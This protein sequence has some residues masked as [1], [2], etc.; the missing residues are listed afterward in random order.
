MKIDAYDTDTGLTCERCA[1]RPAGQWH[2][3]AISSRGDRWEYL[4][5]TCHVEDHRGAM[6]RSACNARS[7]RSLREMLADVAVYVGLGL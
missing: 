3:S 1:E 6:G 7:R 4:C 2:Y 5:A